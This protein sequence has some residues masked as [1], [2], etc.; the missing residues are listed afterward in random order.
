MFCIALCARF[1]LNVYNARMKKNLNIFK[2]LT[3]YNYSS[4]E[5]ILYMPDDFDSSKKYPLLVYIHGYN[6][7]G[8]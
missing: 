7:F 5:S 4:Q 1:F 6:R 3:Y 2:Y 8:A